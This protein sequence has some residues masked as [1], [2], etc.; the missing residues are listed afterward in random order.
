[1]NT[2]VLHKK[3]CKEVSK[4]LNKYFTNLTKSHKLKKMHVEEELKIFESICK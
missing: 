2:I 3:I 4:V 1:M